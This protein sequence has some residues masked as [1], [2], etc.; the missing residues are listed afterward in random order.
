ML[1]VAR[2]YKVLCHS[3]L[4]PGYFCS[5]IYRSCTSHFVDISHDATDRRRECKFSRSMP[6]AQLRFSV[7]DKMAENKKPI[8]NSLN[9]LCKS[10]LGEDQ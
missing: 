3:N 10:C 8:R 1:A 9:D 5:R 6:P 7:I 4:I 2:V